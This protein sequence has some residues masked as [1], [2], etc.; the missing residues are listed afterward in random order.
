V[1]YPIPSGPHFLQWVYAKDPAV[2]AG[3]DAAWVDHVAWTG[4]VPGMASVD[5]NQDGIVDLRDLLFLG[6]TYGTVNPI[7]N[8]DGS[9][10]G[11]VT[12]ADLSILLG[13][14]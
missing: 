4:G 9:A 5:T 10:D 2:T 14:L 11:L 6:K 7:C 13:A 8:L 12:D 1:T 3:S